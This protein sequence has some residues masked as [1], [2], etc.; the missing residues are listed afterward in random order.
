MIEFKN[1]TKEF[2]DKVV[3]SDISM[4]IE[5]QASHR[6]HRTQRMWQDYHLEDDKP[7]DTSDG[8]R[9]LYRRREY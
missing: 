5:D 8:R 3:L 6:A 2:K 1:V 7:P 4:E 9:Y